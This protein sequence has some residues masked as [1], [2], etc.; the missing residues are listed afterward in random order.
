[1]DPNGV[2]L[3]LYIVYSIYIYIDSCFLWVLEFLWL[4][5]MPSLKCLNPFRLS[6]LTER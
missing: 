3:F 4:D 5:S 1:M 2:M 6:T